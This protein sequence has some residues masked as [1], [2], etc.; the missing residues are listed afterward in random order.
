ML[1]NKKLQ[2]IREATTAFPET[3]VN[4]AIWY[5][6]KDRF[7][8]ITVAELIS[9][10]LRDIRWAYNLDGVD[11]RGQ[12]LFRGLQVEGNMLLK[13]F[14]PDG[15][16]PVGVIVAQNLT[17]TFANREFQLWTDSNGTRLKLLFGGVGAFDIGI[18]TPSTQ[19]SLQLEGT[20]FT[21][22]NAAGVII[23]SGTFTRGTLRET[24][25]LTTFGANADSG[26]FTNF[27][28]GS[29]LDVEIDGVR[30]PMDE[31]TQ[32]IQLPKPSGLGAELYTQ[33]VIEN[34]SSKGTQWNYLG[35]GRW[36]L[37]GDGTYNELIFLAVQPR[38]YLLEFEIES[39]SGG[40][41]RCHS[42]ATQTSVM[43]NHIFNSPGK[44]RFAVTNFIAGAYQSFVRHSGT[45]NC[46][47]KNIS[48]RPLFTVNPNELVT[49]GTFSSGTTGWFTK[50]GATFNVVGGQAQLQCVASQTSRIEQPINTLEVGAYYLFTATLV[51][52]TGCNAR[53]NVIRDTDGGYRGLGGQVVNAGSTNVRMQHV[54][55]APSA[56]VIVQVSNDAGPNP[57]TLVW[58][59]V[60]LRKLDS[61]CNPLVL[62]NINPDRWQ[63]IQP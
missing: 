6:L 17:G 58:D 51:S 48:C 40:S 30:W 12:L 52:A 36:Q 59:D 26:G 60:S 19:Y 38:A 57:G 35:A 37:T 63:E 10:Y 21:L 13:F 22:R 27:F 53:L 50:G 3:P 47:I 11:D 55:K 2:L 18:V 8:G 56:S 44:Y 9:K 42:S 5:Y 28:K 31:P 14:T 45:I 41:L 34:P 15:S 25:A 61:L 43:T 32:T 49:N 23:N 54:F 29:Q 33:S 39:I 62:A 7:T 46:V 20:T 1:N 16:K 24:T 4:S